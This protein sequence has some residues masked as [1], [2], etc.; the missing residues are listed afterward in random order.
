MTDNTIPRVER[1]WRPIRVQ[2][3]SYNQTIFRQLPANTPIPLS[4]NV[5][6]REEEESAA[7]AVPVESYLIDGVPFTEAELLAILIAS[8]RKATPQLTD[9]P[10]G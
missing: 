7:A 10:D 3:R 4:N 1:L 6:V 2:H 9:V 5:S 8:Q